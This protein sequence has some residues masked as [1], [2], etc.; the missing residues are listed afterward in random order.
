MQTEAVF[1]NIAERIVSEIGVAKNSI[2]IAVAWFTNRNIYDVLVHKAKEGCQISLMYSADHINDNSSIDFDLLKTKN[3]D[4]FPIGN[5]NSDLMH[6]K[7][8]VIDHCTVITG[9]YNWSNK[10]ESNHENITVT[11][12]VT[13][14]AQQFIAEFNKIRQRYYPESTTPKKAF[15]LGKIIKR[16]EILKNFVFLEEIDELKRGASK[17]KE[18]DYNSDLDEIILL[19]EKEDFADA[20]SKIENFISR[21]QQLSIWTDP[22]IAALK[23]EIKNIENQINAFDNEKIELEKILADFQHRHS[24]ELGEII[25]G[26]LK[27][28]KKKFKEDKERFEEAKRDEE[29]YSSQFQEEKDKELYDLTKEQKKELKRKFRKATTLCHPDKF[30]N[31]PIEVQ[32]Q[33]EEIFKELNDANAKNDIAR[34]VEILE[35]LEKGILKAEKGDSI[36]DKEILRATI[37]RLKLK[38]K[39]LETEILNIQQSDTFKMVFAIEDWD[40]YFTQT[41]EKLQLELEKLK[42]EIV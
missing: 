39:Q 28:R 41:K 24:I 37:R 1:E 11:Y 22:E 10:A 4:I 27:L 12:G 21:N 9:S 8:C 20:I 36:S 35:G 19:I 13:S 15:S 29:E 26:I 31:E 17:L 32:K 7:F 34:V 40:I 42:K 3:A 5:G 6:N 14:L 18:Y 23:L 30:S 16:L 2:F 25:L 38:L 33:A